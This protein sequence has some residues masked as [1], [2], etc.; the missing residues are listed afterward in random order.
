MADADSP[1]ATGALPSGAAGARRVPFFTFA[2]GRA[3]RFR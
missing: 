3:P 2:N 1:R